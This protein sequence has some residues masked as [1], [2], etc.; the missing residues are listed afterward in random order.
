MSAPVVWWIK[1]DFRLSDNPALRAALASGE[2][3]LPVFLFEP[4]LLDGD[5]TSGFHVAAWC[6]ALDDLR[7]RLGAH[8]GDVLVIHGE[9]VDAFE[10]IRGAV[11]IAAIHSHEE[12]GSSVTYTR[13]K[14]VAAWC[15]DRGVP[16]HEHR[17]TGVFRGPLDRNRRS[18][19]WKAFMGE[20]PLAPP[21][22]PD[23]ARVRIPPEAAAMAVPGPLTPDAFEHPLTDAQWGHRQDVS[24]SAAE[25]CLHGFLNDRG[26]CYAGGI[27]SPNLAFTC[28]SRLSV[29]LA[30]G[31][32]TGRGVYAALG[33][34]LAELKADSSPEAKRWRKSLASFR[35][36]L[37]WRDHFIQRLETE[38]QM[39]FTA[40][41]PAYDAMPTPGDAHFDAWYEGRTG[42]P[43]VDACMRCAHQ[44]GFLNFR[45]R[46]MVTS[47]AVHSL[48]IDWR[49]LV[50]PVA[51]IWA[52]YEPGIHIAQTQMQAG[53]VGI[54][55]L[56]VYSPNKQLEDH[57]PEAAFVKAWVPELRDT[58]PEAILRHHQR[59]LAGY[60]APLVD[61][62]ASSKEMRADYYAIK[63]TPE[64]K[65]HAERVYE[66]H[67]SRRRAESRTW[68]NITGRRSRKEGGGDSVRGTRPATL[69]L[70]PEQS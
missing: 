39:E 1:K 20:G 47:A 6:E 48:R 56:R 26:F 25:E 50:H 41:N 30:W 32:L 53:V 28:G 24:E 5:E 16:W 63:R 46:A 34:R 43:L 68:K 66:R 42:W 55:Q 27:S 14:A 67:G 44:T 19:R 23:L 4:V 40:L 9:A 35:S 7:Q 57:D 60:P 10:R 49:L 54:N 38:P 21:Q 37:H 62:W 69:P 51:R 70:F 61:W 52:D 18:A 64:A 58:P 11:G 31:T 15:R 33:E 12:I 29:H 13:D 3:V 65:A 36:R 22:A 45:M 2:T 59:P 17:Q 8:G